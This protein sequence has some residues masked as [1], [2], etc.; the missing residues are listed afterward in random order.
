[1][2]PSDKLRWLHLRTNELPDGARLSRHSAAPPRLESALRTSSRLPEDL[3]WRHDEPSRSYQHATPAPGLVQTCRKH[4]ILYKL[5]WRPARHWWRGH[6]PQLAGLRRS[7]S[8]TPAGAGFV[9]GRTRP[10]L[11][12][13]R[14]NCSDLSV[15][16]WL[17]HHR[18]QV[19]TMMA[20]VYPVNDS[21]SRNADRVRS[22][23]LI[24]ISA[25]NRLSIVLKL[26]WTPP[27]AVKTICGS[28]TLVPRQ[29]GVL[30]V[31]AHG[32]AIAGSW[33][34]DTATNVPES[35]Q[36]SGRKLSGPQ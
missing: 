34:R 22:Y 36:H 21:L 29:F 23:R 2:R 7:L 35:G 33:V 31:L 1:M 3:L 9:N 5:S 18:L 8:A 10:S 19:T 12:P 32:G 16:S 25:L 4:G 13:T 14:S 26:S 15:E 28:G 17:P 30:S 27:Q 24:A 20:Q 11:E 6:P